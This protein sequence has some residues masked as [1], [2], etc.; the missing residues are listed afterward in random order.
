MTDIDLLFNEARDEVL[1]DAAQLQSEVKIVQE[2]IVAPGWNG[3]LHG[4]P[5]TLYGYMMGCFSSIDLLSQY[6]Q[7]SSRNQTTRMAAYMFEGLGYERPVSSVAVQLW[8]HTLMHTANPRRIR[9]NRTG[10]SYRW[11]LHWGSPYLPVDQHM[12]FQT[13]AADD[14]ILGVGLNY[15]VD[16]VASAAIALCAA[17]EQGEEAK[18]KMARA[19]AQVLK[20]SVRVL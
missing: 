12:K 10:I 15:L 11:L 16:D 20:Q 5:R 6:W 18:A 19:H 4:M 13:L 3:E 14:W 8:R 7:G 2:Q 1:G 17:A 9:D